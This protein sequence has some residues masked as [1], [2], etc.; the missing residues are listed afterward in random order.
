MF[1]LPLSLTVVLFLYHAEQ[2]RPPV[3]VYIAIVGGLA[4]ALMFRNEPTRLEKA[5]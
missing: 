4:A 3:G 2:Y 5:A 1:S